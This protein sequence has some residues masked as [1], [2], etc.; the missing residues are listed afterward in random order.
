[1]KGLPGNRYDSRVKKSFECNHQLDV[2]EKIRKTLFGNS[3]KKKK[4]LEAFKTAPINYRTLIIRKLVRFRSLLEII[5]RI[6]HST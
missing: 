1:M 6:M 5:A 4:V 2:K 3:L